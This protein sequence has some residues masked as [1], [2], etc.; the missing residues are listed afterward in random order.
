MEIVLRA[1]IMFAI[2]YVLLRLMG[3]RELGQM[4]PFELVSLIVMGDLIQQGVTHQDFSLTGATLA[5]VTFLGWS[6]LLGLLGHHSAR[7]RRLLESSPVVLVRSG[8]VL[9]RNLDIER[10]DRDELAIE[11]R[12]A[13][14]AR[15][16]QV[17][18]AILEPEGKI[19][20]IRVDEG[21][22]DPRQDDV[23]TD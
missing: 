23:Q 1:S 14:I 21:D 4:A 8:K 19:S 13:G 11:M 22:V 15:L 9:K 18:W 5:I 10:I 2:M 12:L 3:K 17:A 7:A 6:L 16:D 20:F